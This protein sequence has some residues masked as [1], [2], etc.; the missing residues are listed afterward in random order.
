MS[1]FGM[2]YPSKKN[3]SLLILMFSQIQQVLQPNPWENCIVGVSFLGKFYSH[4]VTN[5]NTN[6]PCDKPRMVT[7]LK[8][9]RNSLAVFYISES[10]KLISWSMSQD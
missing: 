10:N 9:E 8:I 6:G 4:K 5:G 2:A 1:Y 3:I 7:K